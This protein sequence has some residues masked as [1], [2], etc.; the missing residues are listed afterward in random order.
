[1]PQ[2]VRLHRALEA[3]R[4]HDRQVTVILLQVF[5]TIATH[6]KFTLSPYQIAG[7]LGITQASVS[8]AIERLSRPS[9]DKEGPRLGGEM[10]G[11]IT[12]KRHPENHRLNVLGLTAAGE[13]LAQALVRI[14]DGRSNDGPA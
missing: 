3:F 12:V 11:L 1:M 10:L 4:R 13:N 9:A 6:P 2:L 7:H 8:H 14:L 5:L